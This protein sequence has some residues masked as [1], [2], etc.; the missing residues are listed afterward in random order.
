[1]GWEP[2]V[3]SESSPLIA[4]TVGF[5]IRE[6]PEYLM[7]AHSYDKVNDHYNG[8]IRIPICSVLEMKVL[9]GLRL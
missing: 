7:I 5:M 2:R 3:A 1:M 9:C 4:H 8:A 6:S